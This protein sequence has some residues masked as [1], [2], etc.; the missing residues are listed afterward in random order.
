MKTT[1]TIELATGIK[2]DRNL[3]LTPHP[4]NF[5]G[6]AC[7]EIKQVT[8]NYYA[9]PQTIT[10]VIELDADI[11]AVFGSEWKDISSDSSEKIPSI[12]V[13][14]KPPAPAPSPIAVPAST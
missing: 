3:R 11:E 4:Q 13:Q 9:N 12:I 6:A 14:V 2:L 10:V 7:F 1:A 5:K 8:C